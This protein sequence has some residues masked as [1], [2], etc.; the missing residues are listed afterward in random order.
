M[1][2]IDDTRS[3]ASTRRG[4][5]TTTQNVVAADGKTAST[6]TGTDGQVQKVN[7]VGVR[8]AVMIDRRLTRA[9]TF[10]SPQRLSGRE[11]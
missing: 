6:T 11:R 2:R 7:N 10:S 8:E 1:K 4:K 3:R 9:T 5:V